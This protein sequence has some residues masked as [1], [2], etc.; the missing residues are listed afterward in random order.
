[1]ILANN[2]TTQ[3]QVRYQIQMHKQINQKDVYFIRV[4]FS[5]F[6]NINKDT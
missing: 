6:A 3:Q 1:M 4:S 2:I 5:K